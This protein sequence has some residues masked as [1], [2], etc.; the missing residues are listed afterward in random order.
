MRE[1][2]IDAAIAEFTQSGLKFTMSDL[3]KDLLHISTN[4]ALYWEEKYGI[5]SAPRNQ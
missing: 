2:I 3:A 1:K 5:L 4:V